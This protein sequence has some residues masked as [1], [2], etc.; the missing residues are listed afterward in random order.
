MSAGVL[1][2]PSNIRNIIGPSILPQMGKANSIFYKTVS[3]VIC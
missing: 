1:K 2:Q 3:Y